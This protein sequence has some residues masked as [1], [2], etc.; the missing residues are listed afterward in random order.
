MSLFYMGIGISNIYD[1]IT[2]ILRTWWL[3]NTKYVLTVLFLG[4]TVLSFHM[5]SSRA[6]MLRL[7]L[8]SSHLQNQLWRLGRLRADRCL[9]TSVSPLGQLRLPPSDMVPRQLDSPH[10]S[11][12]PRGSRSSHPPEGLTWYQSH[13]Q[14][15]HLVSH[16]AGPD[17]RGGEIGSASWCEEWRLSLETRFNQSTQVGLPGWPGCLVTVPRMCLQGWWP[18]QCVSWANTTFSLLLT[19]CNWHVNITSLLW[20]GGS[21]KSLLPDTSP[22]ALKYN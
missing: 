4:R 15:N 18:R 10:C 7:L 20:C 9:S 11:F 12:S 1:W 21:S 14:S 6:E 17:S 19:W 8:Y 13:S 3:L 16:R 2:N 22:S 5:L